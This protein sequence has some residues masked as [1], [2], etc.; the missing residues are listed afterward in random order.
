MLPRNQVAHAANEKRKRSRS[1][2]RTQSKQPRPTE[3]AVSDEEL[4]E[5]S[6]RMKTAFE[7]TDKEP[8]DFQVEAGRAQCRGRDV[9]IHARTGIG[10]TAVVAAPYAFKQNKHRV[11]IFVSPLIAL[12][13]EMVETF[14]EEYKLSAIAVNSKRTSSLDEVMQVRHKFCIYWHVQLNHSTCRKSAAETTTSF[15]SHRRCSSPARSLTVSFAIRR[16]HS[17]S[18]LWSSM[19][20]TAFRIGEL[21]SARSMA[22]LAVS[23]R[24]YRRLCRSLQCPRH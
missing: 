15:S 6:S 21:T 20:L 24:F 1:R 10:K 23:V 5:I 9:L 17:V 19:K 7:W 18:C 16:S 13:E 22:L 8:H 11:T 4:K 3:W 2:E 14:R 12:Q